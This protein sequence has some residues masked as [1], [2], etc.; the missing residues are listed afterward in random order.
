MTD[1]NIHCGPNAVLAMAREGYTWGDFNLKDLTETLTY[2]G[3]WRLAYKNF[4]EGCKEVWRS[5][6]K[7]A[8]TKS[9]QRLIPEV[10]EDDLVPSHAGV[11]AQAL[12]PDGKCVDDFLIVPGRDS[13]HVCN[14]PSPAATASIPIG[15]AVVEQIPSKSTK[16]AV[17]LSA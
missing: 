17:A 12:L 2:G 15:R 13:M 1:G 10:Q 8:F 16:T 9:L 11:R 14:A 7:K 4:G 6:S 5:M 3:F